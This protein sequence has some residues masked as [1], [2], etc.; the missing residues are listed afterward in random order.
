M[1]VSLPG[2]LPPRAA[3]ARRGRRDRPGRARRA[4]HGPRGRL[5]ALEYDRLVLAVGSVNKLLPVPGRRRARA[6]LPR[7]ARG[8]VPARPRHPADRAGRRPPTTRR[9][10]GARRT[11]VVVGAGYTGT[12]VAAQG[13]LFTDALA[14]KQPAA[15]R[16]RGRAG[17]CSTSP[18][19]VLPELDRGCPRPPTGCCGGAASTSGPGPRSRRPRP[20]ESC[21]TTGSSSTRG[22]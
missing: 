4:L 22:R 17:C 9:N 11:F 2:T 20:T 3:G 1:T 13:K 14:R 21:W 15:G 18:T 10:C 8:A 6:R 5:G 16:A 7:A 12:E 19:R